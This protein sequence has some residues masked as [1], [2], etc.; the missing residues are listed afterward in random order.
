VTICTEN[1]D[2][3]PAF[4]VPGATS[5]DEYVAGLV[6]RVGRVDETLATSGIT[7]LIEHLVLHPLGADDSKH[8]NG[9]T[10]ALTTTFVASGSAD[11]IVNFF[12]TVTAGLRELPLERMEREKRVLRAEGADSKPSIAEVILRH[13]YGAQGY[14]LLSFPE[15]GLDAAGPDELAAW[16]NRGFT[17][18]N[19]ALWLAGGPP[20]AQLRLNLPDGERTPVPAMPVTIRSSPAYFNAN[21]AGPGFC[22][23]V[24]R[25]SAAQVYGMIL[26]A[27][28]KGELRHKQALSY[29]PSAVYSV[30]DGQHAHI[31]AGADGTDES[32]SILVS[33]FIRIIARLRDKPVD[34]EEIESVADRMI[35][36]WQSPRSLLS[37]ARR[38]AQNELLG[39]GNNTM[40][41]WKEQLAAVSPE[42]VQRV[43][44]EAFDNGV[45]AL[46]RRQEPFRA[47][48][49]HVPWF[50]SGAAAGHH[51]RSA[52]APFVT[53]RLILGTEGVSIVDAGHA[54]TIRYDQCAALR[55]WSDGARQVIGTDGISVTVEPTLWQLPS[56]AVPQIDSSI[57]RQRH[58]TMPYREPSQ[59][60]HP[61]TTT[62]MRILG[63]TLKQPLAATAITM[64]FVVGLPLLIGQFSAAAG[65]VAGGILLLT[66]FTSL[67]IMGE[68]RARLWLAA[69]KRADGVEPPPDYG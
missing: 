64:V 35:T 36:T 3:I 5:G 11:E 44:A 8:V 21:V 52:D 46:P 53:T 68:M 50:S 15:M 28:L 60:P 57:P 51:A 40:E 58:V 31:L 48:I 56:D 1:V 16:I 23:L 19:A 63:R 26:P 37:Q 2:G 17:Q 42:D 61:G 69:A 41:T 6:F 10:E 67:S 66:I 65:L 30:R 32:V 45:F 27:R 38:A 20:P 14:G 7:H 9:H 54:L 55:V 62:G 39:R 25:S 12:H 24:S 47:E 29:S 13:R 18:R 4:W 43:A 59:I 49:R 34:A 33:E 22:G